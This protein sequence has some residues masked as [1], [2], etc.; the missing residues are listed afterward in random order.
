MMSLLWPPFQSA[1]HDPGYIRAYPPGVREN[2]GQYTHGVLWTVLA[3]TRLGQG[4][5]AAA[6]F[7]MLNP[8]H[9]GSSAS[10]AAAYAVE[11]YVV[12]ADISASPGYAGHGGWT[13]YTGAAAWMYRIGLENILGVGL[14]AGDLVVSPCVPTSFARYEIDYRHGSSVYRVVVENPGRVSSGVASLEVDGKTVS[15]PSGPRIRLVDDGRTH[16]VRVVLGSPSTSR[17]AG[18]GGGPAS[19]GARGTS[20]TSAGTAAETSE[21]AP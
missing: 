18:D 14:E 4:D 20:V 17:T 1:E 8:I 19:A 11:P 3:R 13:W 6:L 9:H 15:L 5:R 10:S 2:G 21:P 12:A 16:D 7:S